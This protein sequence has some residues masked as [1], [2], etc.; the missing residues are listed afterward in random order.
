MAEQLQGLN[1]HASAGS[2]KLYPTLDDWAAVEASRLVA[3]AQ[4]F[5]EQS[6]KIMRDSI[7]AANGVNFAACVQVSVVLDARFNLAFDC[8]FTGA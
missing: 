4:S 8:Y 7:V 1:K 2:S 3:D 5:A 6:R